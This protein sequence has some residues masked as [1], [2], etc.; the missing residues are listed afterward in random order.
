M[1]LENRMKEAYANLKAPE[2]MFAVC[3]WDSSNPEKSIPTIINAR[4][5]GRDSIYASE[6]YAG[7]YA[8]MR[9]DKWFQEMT[10]K[11]QRGEQIIGEQE[12]FV[13]NDQGLRIY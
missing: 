5:T 10:E 3:V 2:G 8:K 6:K 12:Y 7:W 9:N 13:I 1:P 4:T 11:K